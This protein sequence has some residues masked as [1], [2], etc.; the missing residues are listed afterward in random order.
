MLCVVRE[1]HDRQAM[2]VGYDKPVIVKHHPPCFAKGDTADP[3]NRPT[4]RSVGVE[5]E[6]IEGAIAFVDDQ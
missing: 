6:T 2:E 5:I 3:G 1:V 4:V